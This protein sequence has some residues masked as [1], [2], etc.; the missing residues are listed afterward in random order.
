[1]D[2]E[3]M[4]FG[5]S[6]L[7]SSRRYGFLFPPIQFFLNKINP[8]RPTAADILLEDGDSL[9]EYG[10]DAKVIHTPGH[11][12]GHCCFIFQNGIAF[13][14]DLIGRRF[15]PHIQ[16]LLATHWLKIPG[17]IQKLK[18]ENPDF[19]YTGHSPTPLYN[20]DLQTLQS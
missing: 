5:E 6:P 7:G 17:S 2:A 9:E 16:N 19:I 10:L 4:I 18:R 14:G 1:M 20:E 3:S 12:A 11:T 15:G 13:S 8:I